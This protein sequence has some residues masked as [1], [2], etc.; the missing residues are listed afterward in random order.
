MK[1]KHIF[2]L[3][4]LL[5]GVALA[6]GVRYDSVALN[7]RG[8]PI[9][10]ATITLC[11]GT[12]TGTPCSPAAL[13]YTDITTG[14]SCASGFPVVLQGQ[15]TCQATTDGLGNFGFWLTAGTYKYSI[16]GP[17]VATAQTYTI[18]I[19][20]GNLQV[21]GGIPWCDIRA[22]GGDPTGVSSNTTAL[23]S[24]IATC[25][26]TQ[27]YPIYFPCGQYLFNSAPAALPNGGVI[28]GAGSAC[29]TLVANYNEA[30]DV[31]GFFTW[32]G[33]VTS[34]GQG[35]LIAIKGVLI[36]KGSTNTGGTALKFTGSSCSVRASFITIDDVQVTN[37]FGT[38]S[39]FWHHSLIA[40][41][42]NCTTAGTQGVRDFSIHNAYFAGAKS[43][44]AATFTNFAVVFWN[45]VHVYMNH[46]L[47]FAP[48][49]PDTKMSVTVSGPG[50]G[51]SASN[52]VYI[53]N[54]EIIGDATFDFVTNA[55]FSGSISG[56]ATSTG[57]AS[58]VS[59][60]TNDILTANSGSVN[61]AN[62]KATNTINSTFD[63]TNSTGSAGALGTRTGAHAGG[64]FFP[65]AFF[66]EISATTY[67]F[68]ANSNVADWFF[69]GGPG[70]DVRL[71]SCTFAQLSAANN[72]ATLY[73]SD[74]NA[75]CTAG[76]ST[77]RT[78]FRENG[79]WTH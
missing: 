7:P 51:T 22:Y 26:A 23:N 1:M 58:G 24:A 29:V 63:G 68:N 70:S 56:T 44:A 15:N 79:V 6:Q 3:V 10:N 19:N 41:G 33:H 74:C 50:A 34:G 65:D 62:V 57:N 31:N 53:D 55:K 28:L 4:V 73:C 37:T 72:G 61:V 8:A 60:G 78:C 16:S 66:N 11:T 13:G 40:D 14:T 48:V 38:G 5:S 59:I 64:L 77:G 12:A 32:D 69:T 43:S 42:S 17:S 20:S 36:S 27:S 71:P 30:T 35:G 76:A 52:N 46:V 25:T 39:G 75:T 9:P 54:T 2:W 49:S 45:A 21:S 47:T 67:S 18:T